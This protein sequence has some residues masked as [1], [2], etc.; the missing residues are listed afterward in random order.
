MSSSAASPSWNSGCPVGRCRSAQRASRPAS[1][2]GSASASAWAASSRSAWRPRS[3]GV[4]TSLRAAPAGRA[5]TGR[6]RRPRPARRRRSG[7]P[8]RSMRRARLGEHVRLQ[9]DQRRVRGAGLEQLAAKHQHGRRLERGERRRPPSARHE[10]RR[11]ADDLAGG[12][13]VDGAIALGCV[14]ARL[15]AQRHRG[16]QPPGD[17]EVRPG[18]PAPLRGPAPRPP[19]RRGAGPRAAVRRCRRRRAC[20]APSRSAPGRRSGGGRRRRDPVS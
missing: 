11:L 7:R 3:S 1:G 16:A 10:Q 15:A 12:D 5:A 2:A 9:R 18:R 17:E 4:T 20:V 14:A 13:L 6:L 8:S 19:R